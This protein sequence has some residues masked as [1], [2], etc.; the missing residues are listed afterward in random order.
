MNWEKIF[1]IL[2]VATAIAVLVSAVG[3]FFL[4]YLLDM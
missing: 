1:I 3:G 4:G 2:V